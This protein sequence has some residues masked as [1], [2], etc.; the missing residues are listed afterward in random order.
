MCNGGCNRTPLRRSRP[1]RRRCRLG[2]GG[3]LTSS[4][5]RLVAPPPAPGPRPRGGGG[6]SV[7]GARLCAG[8]TP[9]H[10][11]TR[12]RPAERPTPRRARQRRFRFTRHAYTVRFTRSRSDGA[13]SRSDGGPAS[14]PGGAA[15]AQAEFPPAPAERAACSCACGGACGGECDRGP[16]AAVVDQRGRGQPIGSRDRDRERE[17]ERDRYL[18][19][20]SAT[21]RWSERGH[22]LER[23]RP[24]M[25]AAAP[26]GLCRRP[27]SKR[28][29][30]DAGCRDVSRAQRREAACERAHRAGPPIPAGRSTQRPKQWSAPPRVGLHV[31]PFV[32]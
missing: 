13:R 19:H 1:L 4:T 17:R 28:G 9:L 12:P 10:A 11:P 5:S 31:G 30:V 14:R 2:L 7:R 26:L 27:R 32:C 18:G 21:P 16:N 6:P 20:G 25:L 29:K 22:V 23:G 24:E 15:E 8:H 3:V